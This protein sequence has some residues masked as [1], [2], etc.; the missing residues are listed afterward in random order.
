MPYTLAHP[1]A[2][3]PI[4]SL[5]RGRLRLAALALGAVS[6]DLQY[7]L[8]LNT[9]GRFSHSLSGLV[10]FCLPAGWLALFVFDRWGRRGVQALLPAPLRLPPPPLPPRPFLA[11]TI[12]LLLGALAHV[13]WDSFTHAG[14]W[15]VRHLPM[16]RATVFPPILVVPWFKVLQHGST[17]VGLSILVLAGVQWVRAQPERP[18]GPLLGRSIGIGLVLAVVGVAN[19]LRFR[20]EGL[21]HVI[22][23]GAVAIVA[24][25][26]VGLVLLGW[27]SARAGRPLQ[28]PE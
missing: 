18:W 7:I 5:F 25:L 3:V 16:L 19:G 20:N 12:A 24:A 13:V 28:W 27:L 4:H 21:T 22:V 17:L 6:P 15:G 26:G 23:A 11:T 14:G 9:E 10:L 2:I 8:N 1:A